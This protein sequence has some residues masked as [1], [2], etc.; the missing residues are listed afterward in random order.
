MSREIWLESRGE[1]AMGALVRVFGCVDKL[2]PFETGFAGAT[3]FTSVAFEWLLTSV[4]TQMFVEP[5]LALSNV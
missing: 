3:E 4:N 5:I 1:I 2:M